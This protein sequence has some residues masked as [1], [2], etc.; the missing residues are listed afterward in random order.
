MFIKSLQISFATLLVCATAALAGQASGPARM[1][2]RVTDAVGK[3]VPGAEIHLKGVDGSG[4][5]I[6]RTDQ[7]GR[8]G[9]GKLPVTDYDITLFVNGQ[10]KASLTNM[11][12]W[13]NRPTEQNFKLT[14]K[15]VATSPAS[16]HTHM[17]YVP[18]ETGSNLG[19]R[20]VEVDDRTG[21]SSAATAGQ[22][23]QRGGSAMLKS[24]QGASGTSGGGN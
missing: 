5:R 24:L 13:N 6:T 22:N 1:E 16:K 21:N 19:G 4:E 12:V 23:L 3:A 2:G 20:W 17:V 8:Y 18:A 11:K 15:F 9:I 14:G 7:D 10:M